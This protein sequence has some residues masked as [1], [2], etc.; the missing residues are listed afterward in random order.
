MRYR[1]AFSQR[2]LAKFTLNFRFRLW[3]DKGRFKLL[4]GLTFIPLRTVDALV[5][6]RASLFHWWRRRRWRSRPNPR[7]LPGRY[8]RG[9]TPVLEPRR[10]RMPLTR[11]LAWTHRPWW[12][13]SALLT[14][15]RSGR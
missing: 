11:C 3:P 12:I 8:S 14:G 13:G 10:G 5:D 1:D 4:L 6:R 2:D 7:T 9:C 15:R